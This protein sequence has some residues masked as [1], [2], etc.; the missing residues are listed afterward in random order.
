VLGTHW[1]RRGPVVGRRRDIV[2]RTRVGETVGLVGALT[3]LSGQ[4][5][6]VL[7]IA[8]HGTRRWRNDGFIRMDLSFFKLN[9]VLVNV[10][11]A[12]GG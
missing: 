4:T 6:F 8:I 12:S 9:F 10:A 2:G 1:D 11:G 5:I 7:Q 3:G